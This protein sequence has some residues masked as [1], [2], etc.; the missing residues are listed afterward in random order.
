MG[1]SIPAYPL[2]CSVY[3]HIPFC[4]TKCGYCSFFSVPYH[5]A[6]FERYYDILLREIWLVK[7]EYEIQAK[8]V[9][10]GGG[11]PSLLSQEQISKILSLLNPSPSAEI[12]L[13]VNPVQIN[14]S[15]LSQLV[16]TKINRLSLGIQSMDNEVLVKLGRRHKAETL[17]HKLQLCREYG[18]DNISVDFLFGIPGISTEAVITDLQQILKLN[19]EHLSAYLLTL[20][21]NSALADWQEFLPD[22]ET[23]SEQ[24]YAI[25]E[26]MESSGFEHYEISNFCLPGREAKHNLSYWRVQDYLGLGAGASGCLRNIRYRKLE[27]IT[28]WE[29][30]VIRGDF[31]SDGESETMDQLKSDFIIIQFRLMRGLDLAEYKMRFGIDFSEECFKM[32]QKYLS[33]G[34]MEMQNGYLKLTRKAWFVSN[35]IL[36]DFI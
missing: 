25:C 32:I 28:E 9:Y 15:F 7:K 3:L 6:D 21:D 19:P 11:T 14:N 10:F 34:F 27:N 17:N 33:T 2:N 29:Q 35:Y 23:A 18:F 4:L 1:Q 30:S 12:T 5:K 13:E 31:F 16:K 22:E 36:Q 26:E 8:T 24:Y 20:D